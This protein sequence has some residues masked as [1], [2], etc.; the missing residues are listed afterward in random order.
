MAPVSPLAKAGPEQQPE[1]RSSPQTTPVL[2]KSEAQTLQMPPRRPDYSHIAGVKN[3]QAI[4]A[5]QA[6]DEQT[7]RERLDTL[8]GLDE[9]A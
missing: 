8:L 6:L 4:T 9:Y 7:R 5:Y 1:R 3:R 2:A